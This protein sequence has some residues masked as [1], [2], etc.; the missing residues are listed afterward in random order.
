MRIERMDINR[1]KVILTAEDLSSMNLS[2]DRLQPDSG[3]LHAFMFKLM[4]RVKCE[5]GFN[6]YNGQI[7]IEAQ[8]TLDGI[9]LLVTRIGDNNANSVRPKYKNVRAVKKKTIIKTGIYHFKEFNT[10]CGAFKTLDGDMLAKS[11]LYRMNGEYYLVICT[12]LM[13]D[14]YHSLMSEFCDDYSYPTLYENMLREHGECIAR[15]SGLTDMID[16]IKKLY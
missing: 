3:E 16:K 12:D 1:I 10:L 14:D 6:P 13:F 4:E 2:V 7:M 9:T 11:A 15:G 8:P 5:T